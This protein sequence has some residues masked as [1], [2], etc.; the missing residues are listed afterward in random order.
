MNEISGAG[1]PGVELKEW[2]GPSRVTRQEGQWNGQVN[3]LES[4]RAGFAT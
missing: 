3:K 1:C 4:D 2:D